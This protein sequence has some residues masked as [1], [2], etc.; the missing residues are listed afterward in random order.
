M[1]IGAKNKKYNLGREIKAWGKRQVRS[2]KRIWC[3]MTWHDWKRG[4]NGW[5]NIG[6]GVFCA[7]CN[8]MYN[9][10]WIH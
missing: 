1:K 6:T 9:N 7:K 10:P 5:E 2:L 3:W 8:K 4:T